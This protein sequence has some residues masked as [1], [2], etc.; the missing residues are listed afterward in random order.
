MKK[1][2]ILLAIL[3]TILIILFKEYNNIVYAECEKDK[4][5]IKLEQQLIL[6]KDSIAL[7]RK[8]LD[9]GDSISDIMM[10]NYQKAIEFL[11]KENY[12]LKYGK[13]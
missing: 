11:A 4:K 9:R 8:A 7:Y 13:L 3:I 2:L 1:I 12:V 6:Y 10:Y 5:I